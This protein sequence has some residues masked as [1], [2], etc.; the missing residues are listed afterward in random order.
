MVWEKWILC[1]VIYSYLYLVPSL[2]KQKMKFSIKDF[3]SLMWTNMQLIWSYLL[4]KS[5]KE[6]FIFMQLLSWTLLNA[7]TPALLQDSESEYSAFESIIHSFISVWGH[8]TITLSHNDQN[9]DNPLLALVWFRSPPSP[10]PWTFTILLQLNSPL[11]PY[12]NNKLCDFI[13][14]SPPVAICP[15]RCHKNVP[16]I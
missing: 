3:F 14:S 13:V 15:Y 4:E 6:K 8:L 10:L 5:L 7:I 11:T 16:L 9:F 12:Q 1:T 2:T